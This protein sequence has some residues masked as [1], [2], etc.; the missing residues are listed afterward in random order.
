MKA[1]KNFLQSIEK[2]VRK[3]PSTSEVETSA[4]ESVE[5]A[6][7]VMTSNQSN[8]EKSALQPTAGFKRIQEI[9]TMKIKDKP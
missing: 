7:E 2:L 3:Q 4:S 8:K 6:A 5:S 1:L 9:M